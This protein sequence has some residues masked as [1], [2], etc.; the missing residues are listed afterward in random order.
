M[1]L[2]FYTSTSTSDLGLV[3]LS[4]LLS[5]LISTADWSRIHR[6]ATTFAKR[7]RAKIGARA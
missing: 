7:M 1:D 5:F 6:R 3:L 4:F 2:F